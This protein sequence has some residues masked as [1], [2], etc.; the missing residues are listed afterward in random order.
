MFT[1]VVTAFVLVFAL[2]ACTGGSDKPS[3]PKSSAPGSGSSGPLGL[4]CADIWKDGAV[5][6]KD[7]DGCIKDGRA[8]DQEK[9]D[10]QDGTS[11]IVFEE[12]FYAMTGGKITKPAAAPLQDT[13]GYSKA[14]SACTGE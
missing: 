7:Y 13:E 1:K 12:V 11:L 3:G 10:C 14:Y 5:L 2:S 4:A 9:V 8:G 6:P